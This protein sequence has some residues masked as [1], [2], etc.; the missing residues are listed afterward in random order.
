MKDRGGRPKAT[1]RGRRRR[2]HRS[3]FGKD[4]SFERRVQNFRQKIFIF[5]KRG[6]L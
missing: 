5:Q 6:K 1:N 4:E 2:K 3:M